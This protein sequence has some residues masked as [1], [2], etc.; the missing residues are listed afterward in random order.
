MLLLLLA[1]PKP[2]LEPLDLTERL[3]SGQVRAGRITDEQA[4]FGGIAAEGQV[5]DFK[6]YNDRVAFI[7]QSRRQ[8]SYMSTYG[9][10]VIDADIIRDDGIGRDLVI[11]WAPNLGFG[12]F[13]DPTSV[14][15]ADDGRDGTACVRVV[16]DEAAF[17]YLSGGFEIPHVDLGLRV[18]TDYILEPDSYTLEVRSTITAT[19]GEATFAPGDILSGAR[20][21]ADPWEPGVGL[22]AP[23][24]QVSDLKGWVSQDNR[25][26]VGILAPDTAGSGAAAVIEN[27][28]QMEMAFADEVTLAGGESFT[29]VRRYG[30]GPD[31][32]TF[33]D[34]PTQT[35]EGPPGA[36][37]HVL[38]D[39][40]PWSM[41][42]VDSDGSWDVHTP[43]GAEIVLD[44]RGTR[45]IPEFPD[46]AEDYN[47]YMAPHLREAALSSLAEGTDQP[48]PPRAQGLGILNDPA[49]LKIRSDGPFEARL[50]P[51]DPVEVDPRLADDY[52]SQTAWSHSGDFRF[53]MAP[54][55]YDLVVHRGVRFEVFSA[56]VELVEGQDVV[57][58]AP[59]EQAYD[60]D[61]YRLSDPH[62]HA[63]PSSD[64]HNA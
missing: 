11:E 49:W 18:V 23:S 40:D 64:M 56:T 47:P 61:G 37:V 60:H 13:V 9:G 36:R 33:R 24:T 3:S 31:M 54:G 52:R 25:V 32:D 8:G 19:D 46:G 39:G 42:V 45:Y 1:C 15:L 22:D 63:M 38:V 17:Q 53:A 55:A 26:A 59:L 2:H 44:A 10:N 28:M 58:D 51:H 14:R 41:G 29:Y 7:I 5:G 30:V 48:E 21:I 16:G 12:R 35:G 57:I 6:I 50:V 4:L 62:M 20:E 34:G 43:Q 27:L